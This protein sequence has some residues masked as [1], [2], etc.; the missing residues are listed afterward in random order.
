MAPPTFGVLRFK[1]PPAQTGLLLE[2]VGVAGRALTVTFEV[3][4]LLHP[5]DV[6]VKVNVAVPAET[7]VTTPASVTV[8]TAGVLLTHVPPLVGDNV[9]VPPAHMDADPVMFTTGRA[10]TVMVNVHVLVQPLP[11]V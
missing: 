3:G 7:P 2:A 1:L 8:A 4:L 10:F 11:S 9:V 5:V 6:C